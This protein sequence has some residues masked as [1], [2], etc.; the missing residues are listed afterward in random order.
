MIVRSIEQIFRTPV[1]VGKP[2]RP[3]GVGDRNVFLG[4]CFTEHVGKR[5]A[6]A[7]LLTLVNPLGVMY[8]PVSIARLLT[9]QE[10]DLAR[11]FVCYK[12]MWHSWLG[13]STLSRLDSD[14]CRLATNH[15]LSRLHVELARA[16]NLFLTLGTSRY[17]VYRESNEAIANCHRLPSMEFEEHD[18]SVDEI[19]V[20]LE[21]ALKPLHET[22]PRMHVILTVSPYRYAKYGMHESQLAK[23]Q[24]LLAADRML[25]LHPD[26]V[27]YFPAYEIVMDEL[28][29]YR[30]Y[31]EDMLHPSG[32]AVDYIWQR[33][34]DEWMT[35]E[36]RQYLTR[37][38]SIGRALNHRPLHPESP[39]YEA[40]RQRSQEQLQQLQHDYPML[41]IKVPRNL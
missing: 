19:V 36:L 13:D 5:F 31:A 41:S 39:E 29:D 30:F 37:W 28:R 17:Y 11:D 32:Q 4:S 25:T 1:D 18:L 34:Q 6:D 2:L 40:F 8:N 10:S 21:T 3:I 14:E 35:D 9:T 20:A 27:S 26:W 33:L 12:E 16:D 22:N 23:A 24:L 7:R 38:E 15:A